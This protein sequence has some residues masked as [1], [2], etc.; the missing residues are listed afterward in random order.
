MKATQPPVR[1]G[2]GSELFLILL[3]LIIGMGAYAITDLQVNGELPANFYLLS[4]GMAVLGLGLHLIV[5][6]RAKYADPLL[7]PSALVLNGL[8]LAMI[9]RIDL[10]RETDLAERQ[11]M[12]TAVGV[13]GACVIIWLLKDH[14]ILR[15]F[16]YLAGVSALLLTLLP[17]IPGIGKTINGARIWIYIGP[18]SLQ[19]AE[20]AKILLAVFF[21]GYLVNNRDRLA[22]AGPK[23]FGIHLPR[24]ADFG[25]LILIWLAA[26][27]ILIMQKDLGTSL[28]FF[29]LFVAMLYI[30]TQRLSWIIIG[31][32]LFASGAALVVANFSHVQQ[33][34]NG[35]LNAFDNDVYNA[36]G[37]S[38]QL[39]SGLFGMANG[40]LFGT[41]L[42]DGQPHKVPF[43]YSD[44]IFPSLGEELGLMGLFAILTVYM[45]F[46]QRGFH[47]AVSTRDGFGKLLASGLAFVFAWQCFVVIGG[48]TRLI[49]LTGL[50]TPFLAYGGSS[51]LANWLIVGLLIRISDRSRR[52]EYAMTNP[53]RSS[54]PHGGAPVQSVGKAEMNTEVNQWVSAQ[55]EQSTQI[56]T[57]LDGATNNLDSKGDRPNE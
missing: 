55:N 13:V 6:F 16:T 39:V 51:L 28:L 34:F 26:I 49:P 36:V 48:V 44:F 25:P 27:G 21:A 24:I 56:I 57:Q 20:F 1:T 33:R 37:G 41:G 10:A 22:L 31:G 14:R 30:A 8:G 40:G 15:R 17:L 5:R 9:H 46:V 2:R 50:T 52:P 23:I 35:W 32:V 7:V 45:I 53:K 3:A 54:R 12:W 42:G 43:S 18:F 4:F 47:I 29:G 38:G 11:L 19:P